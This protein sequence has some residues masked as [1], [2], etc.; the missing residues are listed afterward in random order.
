MFICVQAVIVG[1]SLAGKVLWDEVDTWLENV[2][3]IILSRVEERM[4]CIRNIS[5]TK[6]VVK[7]ESK[8]DSC[9]EPV[10]IS[11]PDVIL[12]SDIGLCPRTTFK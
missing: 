5:D 4:R 11:F 6:Y 3:A 7:T 10:K 8:R 1:S 9:L 2:M 12:E